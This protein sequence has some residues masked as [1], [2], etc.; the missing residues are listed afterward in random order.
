MWFIYSSVITGSHTSSRYIYWLQ[1][2][3]N[4]VCGPKSFSHTDQKTSQVKLVSL[5]FNLHYFTF[6]FWESVLPWQLRGSKASAAPPC[7]PLSPP[8][9]P[10]GSPSAAGRWPPAA[11][12]E[13]WEVSHNTQTHRHTHTH[14]HFMCFCTRVISCDVLIRSEVTRHK[15]CDIKHMDANK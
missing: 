2:L 1:E 15:H 5:N 6:K 13:P 10:P 9:A 3:I 4:S 11:P 14:T 7:L 12:V 8:R